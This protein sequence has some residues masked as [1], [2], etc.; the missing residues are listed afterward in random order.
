MEDPFPLEGAPF[1]VVHCYGLLYHLGQPRQA[2]EYL[3]HNTGKMLFLETCVSFG[4][5]EEVHLT[6][7]YK[8][9]LNV[10]DKSYRPQGYNIGYKMGLAAGASIRHLHTH[11]IPRYP[12]EI[13]LADLIAGKR[14]L[15]EDPRETQNRT[16]MIIAE[17]PIPN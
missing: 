10:L 16:K 17:K 2:L 7:L 6:A 5:G 11:I 9:L 1:D 14:V 4:S 15:V 3:S 8:Y 13:G 12:R